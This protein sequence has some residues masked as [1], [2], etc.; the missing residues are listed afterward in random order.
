MR[1][2]DLPRVGLR[3]ERAPLDVEPLRMES[4]S[5]LVEALPASSVFTSVYLGHLTRYGILL[6]RLSD[7]HTEHAAA[8]M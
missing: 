6:C 3:V 1:L 5:A 4:L 8:N 7:M 2:E